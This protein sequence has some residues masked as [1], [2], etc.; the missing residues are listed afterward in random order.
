MIFNEFLKITGNRIPPAINRGS[1][2]RKIPGENHAILIIRKEDFYSKN[3][4]TDKR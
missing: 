2:F 1:S 3:L 4:R